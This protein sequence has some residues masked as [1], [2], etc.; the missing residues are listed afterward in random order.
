PLETGR[1]AIVPVFLADRPGNT[2]VLTGTVA[3]GVDFNVVDGDGPF[4]GE[5]AIAGSSPATR[6]LAAAVR[7]MLANGTSADIRV[8]SASGIDAIYA[9]N[10]DPEVA[11]RI[12]G[13]PLLSLA[14]SDSPGSRVW[15]LTV[16]PAS[17][18][19]TA[20]LWHPI[21]SGLQ[22]LAWIVAIVL[23]APVRRREVELFPEDDE[24]VDG[25]VPA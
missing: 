12:D 19:A 25:E 20:P 24:L 11:R 15:T 3:R 10:A 4:L 7:R 8:L 2:L 5:E 23:T 21:V 14:G 9:P 13:A 22:L 16:A 1:S 17:D 6:E 18:H